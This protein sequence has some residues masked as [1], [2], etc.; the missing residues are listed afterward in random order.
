MFCLKPNL[1]LKWRAGLV[2]LVGLASL[3][4]FM[5]ISILNPAANG[6]NEVGARDRLY[7]AAGGHLI[8]PRFLVDKS[9]W[10]TSNFSSADYQFHDEPARGH[11]VIFYL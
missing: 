10:A 5:L 3:I 9:S 6:F 7:K 4:Y 1:K 2:M 11:K 8:A